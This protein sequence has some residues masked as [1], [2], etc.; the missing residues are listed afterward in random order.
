LC[1][2]RAPELDEMFRRCALA[3]LSS[4]LEVDDARVLFERY[5][6][7]DI[8][9]VQEDR[10][11]RLDLRNAPG[12]ALVD[13]HMIRGVREHLFAVLRDILYVHREFE[14]AGQFDLSTSAGVTD[15]VFR[16]LRH[17]GVLEA[18]M[19]CGLVVCWGGHSISRLEYDYTKEVGYTLG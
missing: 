4:G 19:H 15:A 12:G 13:G 16:I 9:L 14:L 2:R 5:R 1:Q 8:D 3:V 6:D 18:R 11:L 17:A 7:F 10:G